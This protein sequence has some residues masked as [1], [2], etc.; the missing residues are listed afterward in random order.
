MWIVEEY[1]EKEQKGVQF[2]IIE[3]GDIEERNKA[4]YGD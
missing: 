3:E 2:G 1:L 4:V